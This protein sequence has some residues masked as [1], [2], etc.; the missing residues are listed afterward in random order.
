VWV[1]VVLVLWPVC[2]WYAGLK[3]RHPGGVLS[4]L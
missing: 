3:R 2:A 4:Y 1:G